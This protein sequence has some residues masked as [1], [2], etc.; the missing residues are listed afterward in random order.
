MNAL[1]LDGFWSFTEGLAESADEIRGG[2]ALLGWRELPE[3]LA[4]G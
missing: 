3:A 4:T 1:L 2:L